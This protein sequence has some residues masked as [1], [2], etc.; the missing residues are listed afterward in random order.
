MKNSYL[1]FSVK[2][3]GACTVFKQKGWLIIKGDAYTKE[4]LFIQMN[5]GEIQVKWKIV[6]SEK[7]KTWKLK[8]FAN[9]RKNSAW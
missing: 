9:A 4:C 2:P 1:T 8:L 6:D 5:L 7:R 3:W